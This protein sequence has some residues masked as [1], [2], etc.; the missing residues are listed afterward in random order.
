[1]L[2]PAVVYLVRHAEKQDGSDPSLTAA[3]H[4]RAEA[5]AARLDSAGVE[6]ILSTD[7]KRTRETA[8]PLSRRTGLE[9]ELYD[10]RRLSEL[11][12]ALRRDQRTVLVVGHSNT[13][14]AF[15]RLLG[16]D[17]GA[18][19]ADDEY[20]RLY[21]VDLADGTTDIERTRP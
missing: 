4:A 17:P 6:R 15:V 2:R 13:T 14:P 20:D 7:T 21:R 12:D 5:L 11:A 8:E 19:I 1:M 16:G 3:G 18:P 9:I 10:H